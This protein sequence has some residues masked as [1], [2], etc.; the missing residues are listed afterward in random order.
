MLDYRDFLASKQLFY[1]ST[2]KTPKKLNP[3]LFPFQAEL[4]RW[5]VK[6][7]RCAIFADTG[8]G[9]TF[10]QL[11]WAKQMDCRTLIIAPLS[12]A[13]QTVREGEKLS[14]TVRYVRA[15][16]EIDATQISI[17]NYEMLDS[18]DAKSFDAVVLDESSILKSLNGKTRRKLIALFAGTPYKLCCTATPAPN[19]IAEIANHAEFL[20]V[21]SRTDVLSTFFVHDDEGW[22]LRGHAKEPFFKWL[23]SWGFFLQLPS[24]LG[25]SDDGYILPPL[26]F[27]KHSVESEWAPEGELFAR[28][29]KGI[30]ERGQVRRDTID[31]KSELASDLVSNNQQWIVWCGLNDEASKLAR[32][33]DGAANVQGS[34]SIERKKEALEDFQD[35]KI[36]VLIT[37]PR[38]AGFGINLQ[39][40]SHQLFFGLNDS[41]EQFYQC[42]RRSFRFGQ[43]RPV[44]VHILT[45]DAETCILENVIKKDK[46]A[47][48]LRGQM[49]KAIAKFERLEIKNMRQVEGIKNE[50]VTYRDQYK[51]L[52]GDC[53]ERISE[54]ESD[55]VGMSVFSPP[56]ISL[57]AYTPTERDIGNSKN[58]DEFF[59]HFSYLIPDLLRVTKPGRNCCVHVSQVPAM[60]VRDG[61]IG[62]KDFRG[63]T[64]QLFENHGWIYHGEVCIDKNPQAQAIRTKSKA[65]LFVQMRKDASWLRPALA[66][67]IL[68]FRKPGE[69]AD[70]IKPDITN[71]QWIEWAHPVWYNIRENETLNFREARENADDRHICPLQLDVIERCVNLWSNR[72]DLILSPFMGIGS[73][74]YIAIKAKRRFVGIELKK[75]YFDTATKNILEAR[76]E[77]EE[78]TL[79]RESAND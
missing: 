41:W 56:F 67:Y 9:K 31:K 10:M 69:N 17:T 64:I 70:P 40:C 63:K 38:I 37:K 52:L 59:S 79:F 21:M 16:E 33:I 34:D 71:E 46:A 47:T 19:D 28:P 58:E 15:Q 66:D 26:R 18:F 73:E 53:I 75:S 68:V 5:A 30:Q 39:N 54:I 61:Y 72:G 49:M 43:K 22:R 51:L 62:L 7:G 44:D 65:L 25:F 29:L 2:G 42:V 55:S 74:G 77:N 35:G 3:I 48:E 60:L 20:G 78:T 11:E 36:K 23:S 6:K 57:Y 24:D 1:R 32:M 27:H 13:R 12:V 14:I 50:T 45:T 76:R 4:T 8:L